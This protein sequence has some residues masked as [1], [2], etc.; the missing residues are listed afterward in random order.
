M[1]NKTGGGRGTNQH[2]IKGK[3]VAKS[4]E[5]GDIKAGRNMDKF[6]DYSNEV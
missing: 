1:K 2:R 3:S 5:K 6:E 4:G